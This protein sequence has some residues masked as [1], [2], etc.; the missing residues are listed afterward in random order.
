MMRTS[1]G[2]KGPVLFPGEPDLGT[3]LGTVTVTDGVAT[4]GLGQ[5]KPVVRLLQ[6]GLGG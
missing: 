5:K 2:K 4:L 1:F 6:E 3:N